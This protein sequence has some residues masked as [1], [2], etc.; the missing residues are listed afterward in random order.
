M[1]PLTKVL[2]AFTITVVLHLIIY[3]SGAITFFDFLFFD[4]TSA[5]KA[6][7]FSPSSSSTVVV[8]IDEESLQMLGQ[9]PWPRIVLAQ[10]LQDILAQK[11]AAVG[12]DILFSEPDRTSPIQ[13]KRFYRQTLG[14]DIKLDGFPP[15]LENHDF[16]FADVLRSGPT[17]LPLFASQKG[18]GGGSCKLSQDHL[19]VL[20]EGLHLPKTNDP[21]C[22][23]L[24]LQQAAH[25]FGY[26][27]AAVDS[28]GVFRRQS[29]I[30]DYE[31]KGLLCFALSMF[32]QI[33]PTL[34]IEIPENRWKPVTISFADKKIAINN[35]GEVLN[36]LYPKEAF[37]RI[38]ASQV[39]A[40]K[41][42]DNL[43]TGKIVLIGASATGLFDHYM[44]SSGD[45][46]PGVFVHAAL[47]E[48][49]LHNN[50]L[51]QPEY[52]KQIALWLSGLFSLAIILLILRRY[53]LLSWGLYVGISLASLLIS[54]QMLERG[55]YISLGYFLAPFSFFFF[56]ISLFFAVFHYVERKRF[57]EDLGAAH[58][59]TIDSMTLVAEFRDLETGAHIIRTKE[60]VRLLSK[61]LYRNGHHKDYLTPHIIDL[62]YRA[63]PLHDIGKVGIPDAILQK[64]GKLNSDEMEIMRT[65]TVIGRA[66]IDNAIN[67]YSRT[68]E[69]LTIAANISYTHHE[70]WD[71]TGYPQGLKGDEIPLEGRL[72]ALADV[73]DALISRRCYQEPS[74]FQV[75]E[76][77]I[78]SFSGEYF[79]PMIVQA[80][81]ALK[82][83][84]R[85]VARKQE[86]SLNFEG[87]TLLA[88]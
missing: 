65:H 70:K 43:F 9:W 29:L 82:Q 83:E 56:I 13:I 8:E 49:I 39:A 27:N 36:P 48:N 30:V 10:V 51:Y 60:Y 14:I 12:F 87:S 11:P 77:V 61:E 84:F 20:P 45:I 32:A 1:R 71:G 67:S 34:K 88:R 24:P 74:P 59:A 15:E 52:S 28:D 79:D 41:I 68:N 5:N 4:L 58:S 6:A 81:L 66:I 2:S 57:L 63:A 55:I 44:T 38:S 72:M 69:F 40:G 62:L 54:W 19:T 46:L 85:E 18:Q 7:P 50:A 76:E 33:D 78:L 37:S 3:F 64:P 86:D 42:P 26:I 35:R 21:L 80:F 73:Y 75:A 25:G 23:F 22:N 47:I 53:Y 17:V 31:Q 16:I